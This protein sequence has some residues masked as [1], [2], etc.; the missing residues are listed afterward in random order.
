VDVSPH[1][2]AHSEYR[3]MLNVSVEETP[4]SRVKTRTTFPPLGLRAGEWVEVRSADEILATLDDTG[5]LESMPFM[6]EMLQYCGKR[7]RVYKS[8]HKTCDT[9]ET[10]VIR[11]M[12]RA[13]HLEGLRCDGSGHGGCQAGCLIYW[14][15]AWLKRV[16]RPA[17]PDAGDPSDTPE[18]NAVLA[19][20][21]VLPSAEGETRERYRC[22]ATEVVR[23]ST[24][25]R[26]RDRW[27]PRFYIQDLRSGNVGLG[28]FI[29]YGAIAVFNAFA[30]WL[31][32]KRYPHLCGLAGSK[33]PTEH[34]GLQ[35][36]QLVQVRSKQE[37]MKTLN[38]G[39]RNRGLLF[40]YEMVPFCE[41]GTYAVKQKVERIINEKTGYMMKLPNPCVILDGATC[42]GKLSA[43][44]MFCPRA[45]YPY[46][47]E[48]WLR[49]AAE[50]EQ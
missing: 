46:W 45:V 48:I 11:R 34:L 5:C 15:D 22:Q 20:T 43:S 50:G 39:L 2:D 1:T 36:G 23:A 21:A 7:F 9:I 26:R 4:S 33:T 31:G 3:S 44:R 47:H 13:V 32:W 14:K 10:Y 17:A 41:N 30:L 25:V 24:E 16:E 49:R 35:A 38:P 19:R 28:E 42:S 40:D 37:I 6:P 18:A 12:A 29:W 27:D 8:A